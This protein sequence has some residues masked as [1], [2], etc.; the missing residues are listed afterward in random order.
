GQG[1]E[2]VNEIAS[3]TLPEGYSYEWAG[4]TYQEQNS[5]GGIMMVL[6]VA[7]IFAFLFLVAQYESW[8]TP[9]PVIL[10]LPVAV[11]GAL[12][13]FRLIGIPISIYGQLGILLLI[14][15]AAK[16]AILIVEFAKEQRELHGL[17][18]LE[19]AAVAARE[20]FRA[21]LMTAFTCVLGVAPML[22]ASGA[23]AASRKAVGST[24]FFGMTSATVIG[25]FLIP[26]LFV[27]FQGLRETVKGKLSGKKSEEE[28][29]A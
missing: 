28:Q 21:V 9:V 29:G 25:I 5:K 18:L 6:V 13:G 2:R 16:N 8:S 11:L 12:L 4:S 7:L 24:L 23:G 22:F 27:V 15:L 1:I 17:T 26:A 3:K 10:S 14:G 20:R 19:A